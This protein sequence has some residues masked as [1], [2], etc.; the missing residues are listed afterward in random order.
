[1]NK[2]VDLRQTV[3]AEEFVRD[4][5]RWL[6]L[7]A[8]TPVTVTRDGADATVLLGAEDYARLR[9]K[10]DRRAY[11]ASEAPRELIEAV[12]ELAHDLRDVDDDDMTL[13][14]S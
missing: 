9:G 10:D 8:D 4:P 2:H 3:S 13:T 7:S 5:E 11:W 1:M 6:S 12:E 14:G